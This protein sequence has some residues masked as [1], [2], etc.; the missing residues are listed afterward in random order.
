MTPTQVRAIRR[1]ASSS[2]GVA[3][4]S[5]R[6]LTSCIFICFGM[7]ADP[8]QRILKELTMLWIK[9]MPKY[10]AECPFEIALAWSK[11][12][13]AVCVGPTPSHVG[14]CADVKLQWRHVTGPLSNMVASL[15]SIGWH[16]ATF[17]EWIAPNGDTWSV[18]TSIGYAFCLYHLIYAIQDQASMMLWA[19]ASEHCNGKGLHDGMAFEFSMRVLHKYR[20]EQIYDRAAALETIMVGAC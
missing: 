16:P 14:E 2:T 11:A 12:K 10:F 20:K 7:R 17:S 4:R 9:I 15:Y 13:Q 19:K 1:L 3:T 6:C 8:W 18:P 5:Q